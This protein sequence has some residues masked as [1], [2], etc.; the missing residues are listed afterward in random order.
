MISSK[1]VIKLKN[2]SNGQMI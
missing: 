1:I 2:S